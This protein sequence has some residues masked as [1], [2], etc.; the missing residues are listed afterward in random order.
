MFAAKMQQALAVYHCPF[1]GSVVVLGG[2]RTVFC[3]EEASIF[4]RAII[5]VGPV[6]RIG[7][8]GWEY[9]KP[10]LRRC[11]AVRCSQKLAQVL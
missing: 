1:A 5:S 6:E 3:A 7:D 4:I 11:N 10:L 8:A 2:L 9:A